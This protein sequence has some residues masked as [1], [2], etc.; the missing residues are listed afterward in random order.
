MQ[1]ELGCKP[2]YDMSTVEI[3][4]EYVG[5]L[6]PLSAFMVKGWTRC[7]CAVTIMLCAYELRSFWDI[8]PS[9]IKQRLGIVESRSRR[10][11]QEL[12]NDARSSCSGR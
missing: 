5:S 7:V 6:Q 8:L 9:D 4:P 11:S 1:T 10:A 2:R 3:A 12:C